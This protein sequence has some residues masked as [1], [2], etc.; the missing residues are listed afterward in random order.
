MA[1][2]VSDQSGLQGILDAL[3]L[4]EYYP[5]KLTPEIVAD[6]TFSL[7]DLHPKREVRN[8]LLQNKN[9]NSISFLLT[10]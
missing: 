10:E 6:K 5:K 9:L 4:T 2:L 8:I 1:E 7:G 3:Q